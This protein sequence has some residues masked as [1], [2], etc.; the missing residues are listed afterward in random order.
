MKYQLINIDHDHIALNHWVDT[1]S[2]EPFIIG[3][4]KM[5]LLKHHCIYEFM[6]YVM[7]IILRIG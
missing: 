5:R 6:S 3:G 4:A 1:W 2:R 7:K